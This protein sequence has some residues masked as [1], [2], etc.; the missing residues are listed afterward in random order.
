V[1][2]CGH[3]LW[4]TWEDL[5]DEQVIRPTGD[6]IRQQEMIL[7]AGDPKPPFGCIAAFAGGLVWGATGSIGESP[8]R[9]QGQTRAA[10][11]LAAC[12]GGI[13]GPRSRPSPGEG[14]LI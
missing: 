8:I 5:G 13:L 4:F 6:R 12:G 11:W 7:G 3:L 9:A 1:P 10:A 14:G 2:R